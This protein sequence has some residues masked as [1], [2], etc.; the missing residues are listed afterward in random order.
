MAI[1]VICTYCKG[2]GAQIIRLKGWAKTGAQRLVHPECLRA[3]MEQAKRRKAARLAKEWER[4]GQ[5]TFGGL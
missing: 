3:S 4:K 2:E 5:Q 1:E